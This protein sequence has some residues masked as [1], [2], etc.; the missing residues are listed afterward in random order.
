M[1]DL[2]TNTDEHAFNLMKLAFGQDEFEKIAF[3]YFCLCRKRF[4]AIIEND[5]STK[6]VDLF[7]GQWIT[8]SDE[9]SLGKMVFW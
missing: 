1:S 9:V 2:I 6:T 5:S 7:R 3:Y 8:G 4:V